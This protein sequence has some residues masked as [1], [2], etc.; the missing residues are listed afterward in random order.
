MQTKELIARMEKLAEEAKKD[1]PGVA[2]ILLSIC[3]GLA[4]DSTGLGLIVL[5]AAK[6]SRDFLEK[7]NRRN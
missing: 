5:A 2:C 6:A 1:H 3:A 7:M 4:A